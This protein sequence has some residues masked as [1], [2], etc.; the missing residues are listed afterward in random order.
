MSAIG[1]S[2]NRSSRGRH[3]GTGHASG[4]PGRSTGPP[5]RSKEPRTPPGP[6]RA[7]GPASAGVAVPVAGRAWRRPRR[8]SRRR[9]HR[10]SR[11][12]NYCH[13]GTGRRRHRG[14]YCRD[15]T[16][17][18][19]H[20]GSCCREYDDRRHGSYC[21]DGTGRRR[22]GSYCREH[23][24]GRRRGSYPLPCPN[25]CSRRRRR[26]RCNHPSRSTHCIRR[27][28]DGRSRSCQPSRTSQPSTPFRTSRCSSQL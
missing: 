23:G 27:D 28:C 19:R 25:L 8:C 7:S 5:E 9:I 15:G 21:R 17:R 14:S 1:E 13:D 12:G 3:D 4:G 18:R 20:R 16:G 2:F 22:R 26:N 10:R 6:E 11:R 24:G